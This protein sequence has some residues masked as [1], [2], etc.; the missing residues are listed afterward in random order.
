V[1]R[2]ELRAALV[3]VGEDVP[4]VNGSNPDDWWTEL[5]G[6]YASISRFVK[7]LPQTIQFAANAEDT[8]RQPPFPYWSDP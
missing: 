2:A 3:V 4:P 8:P 7:M 1:S 5:T 6:R